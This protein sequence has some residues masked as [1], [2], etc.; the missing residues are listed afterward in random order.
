M[1]GLTKYEYLWA[2]VVQNI[3]PS[4]IKSA[5]IQEVVAPKTIDNRRTNKTQGSICRYSH[6]IWLNLRKTSAQKRDEPKERKDHHE[7][8]KII[9]YKDDSLAEKGL[10]NYFQ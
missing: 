5:S 10:I 8:N 6:R 4:E 3:V 7:K 9:L 2:I 1:F